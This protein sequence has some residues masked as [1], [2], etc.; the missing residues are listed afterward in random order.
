MSEETANLGLPLADPEGAQIAG[1]RRINEALGLV[2]QAYGQQDAR[3][4]DKANK[5]ALE[6][7]ITALIDG[8]SETGNT[9]G[10]LL[11]L[12]ERR[13]LRSDVDD[14]IS[15]RE[16]TVFGFNRVGG[17]L[18]LTQTREPC[19][20]SDFACFA[21]LPGTVTFQLDDSGHLIMNNE[22]LS[23]AD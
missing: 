13:A 9:L 14:M 2:D 19:A 8:A 10:K 23:H 18:Q 12:I 5:S 3:L 15:D 4:K 22:G 6:A 16:V 17:H 21:V 11:G 20:A 1:V 7:A